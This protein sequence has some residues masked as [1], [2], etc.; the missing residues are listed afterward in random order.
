M[1]FDPRPLLDPSYWLTIQPPVDVLSGVGRFVFGLFV[2]LFI[3]GIAIRVVSKHR[4]H[5][6]Y[7]EEA[8]G[9]AGTMLIVMGLIGAVLYFFSF[10]QVPLLGARFWYLIW[11]LGFVFWAGWIVR[12]VKVV[13]PEMKAAAKEQHK[14]DK[15]L[16]N[17]K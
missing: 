14:Q 4:E 6:A 11:G 17:K 8:F 1:N 2:I 15:Y 5:D 16:P 7:V 3:L 13:I 12:Y 9:R 10:E